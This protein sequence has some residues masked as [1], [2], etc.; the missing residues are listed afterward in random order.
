[1][2]PTSYSFL[3]ADRTLSHPLYPGAYLYLEIRRFLNRP[4]SVASWCPLANEYA[5]HLAVIFL[6]HID[7]LMYFSH[8]LYLGA[9]HFL[10]ICKCLMPS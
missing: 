4:I 7:N 8:P 10:G 1:M 2:C 5:L 9:T 3:Y 6:S